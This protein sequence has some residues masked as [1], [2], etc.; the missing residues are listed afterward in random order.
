MGGDGQGTQ[1]SPRLGMRQKEQDHMGYE[2][3][4]RQ[5]PWERASTEGPA[6]IGRARKEVS[7]GVEL[8]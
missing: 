8:S 4:L 6:G 5:F 1:G 3:F 7:G 2:I